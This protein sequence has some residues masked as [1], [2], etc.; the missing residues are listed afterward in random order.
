MGGII[1]IVLY[2][3]RLLFYSFSTR[4]RAHCARLKA[5]ASIDMSD[6]IERLLNTEPSLPLVTAKSVTTQKNLSTPSVAIDQ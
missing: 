5:S 2:A 4:I 3:S 1:G 6:M